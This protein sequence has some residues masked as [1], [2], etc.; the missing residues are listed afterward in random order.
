MIVW[1]G[2]LGECF[3]VERERFEGRRECFEVAWE[4]CEVS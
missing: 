4:R 3:E 1:G 2:L